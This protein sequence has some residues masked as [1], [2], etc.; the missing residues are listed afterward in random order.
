MA[1]GCA[2]ARGPKVTQFYWG[3]RRVHKSEIIRNIQY[4]L[5]DAVERAGTVLVPVTS[6]REMTVRPADCASAIAMHVGYS[7]G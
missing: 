4:L 5:Y 7:T 6:T 3:A 2:R 1:S